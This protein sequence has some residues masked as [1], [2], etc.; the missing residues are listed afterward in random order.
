MNKKILVISHDFVKRVNIKIYEELGKN[1]KI[2][3]SCIRPKTL[4][5][6]GK[7]L[8]KDFKKSKS[9]L[10]IFETDTVF[11]NLRFFYFKNIYSIIKSNKPNI[12]IIHNDPVSLQ[13]IFLIF[14]SFFSNFSIY[15]MSN[16]NK[17]I[18]NNNKFNFNNLFRAIILYF[19]NFLIKF[20][21]KKI[22]CISSHIEKNYI[23]L[24]YKKKT[25]LLPL[26]YDRNIFKKKIKKNKKF[27]ISYFGRIS[28]EKGIHILLQSLELVK[29]KFRLY[30]DTS[31]IDDKQY[32]E[33]LKIKFKKI[34]KN[35][36]VRFIKCDHFQISK[37]MSE[38]DL[39]VLPS[40]YEEQYGRVLQEAVACG[41]LV[42]GSNVGAIPEIIGD[43]DLIFEKKNFKQLALK[44]NK[45][46]N[47]NYYKNKIENIYK[48]I[49]KNRT[50]HKQLKI[51][52]KVI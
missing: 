27:I 17:I 3:L 22:L 10:K 44:I 28:Y 15:C 48:K 5:L 39:V 21:I 25:V 35:S 40:I 23:F 30:L 51:L 41:S 29:F 36:N 49:L 34:L 1:K 42:I 37:Y 13:T 7:N 50:L 8:V 2:N 32:F 16:E 24:G 26:G 47:R 14:F 31:H 20:K 46:N 12:V 11:N 43:K 52:K 19:F 6:N 18:K 4:F 38:S 9:N 33:N 45:L